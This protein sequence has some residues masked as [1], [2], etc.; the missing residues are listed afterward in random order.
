[1]TYKVAAGSASTFPAN[2]LSAIVWSTGSARVRTAPTRS[3]VISV[4]PRG[5]HVVYREA[6]SRL[7]GL[8]AT[9]EGPRR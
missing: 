8:A 7:A 5:G 6:V 1:M 9:D 2:G 4:G 3:K